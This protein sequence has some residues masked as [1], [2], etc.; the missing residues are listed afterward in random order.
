MGR[1]SLSRRYLRFVCRVDHQLP[2][3]TGAELPGFQPPRRCRTCG[4]LRCTMVT[5]SPP[6]PGSVARASIAIALA[7][8]ST[9]PAAS[10]AAAA[11]SIGV[12]AAA[13]PLASLVSPAAGTFEPVE[14]VPAGAS[15]FLLQPAA[16]TPAIAA[17]TSFTTTRAR[18]PACRSWGR[19]L[20]QTA[21]TVRAQLPS[22]FFFSSPELAALMSSVRPPM[23]S[24]ATN[25]TGRGKPLLS[26]RTANC[27]AGSSWMF[28][29][30]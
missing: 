7:P 29:A 18:A 4:Y 3:T 15:D 1:S 17:T 16:R 23:Q 10:D 8:A 27:A 21:T 5:E 9:A 6:L 25:T 24:P 28:V 13:A 2:F 11:A 22:T 20:R 19:L 14:P 26:R 12:S 30:V